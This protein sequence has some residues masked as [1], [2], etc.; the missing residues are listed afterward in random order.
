MSRGPGLVLQLQREG[1]SLELTLVPDEQRVTRALAHGAGHAIAYRARS[2]APALQLPLRVLARAL[3]EL[4]TAESTQSVAFR[5]AAAVSRAGATLSIGRPSPPS[6][7]MPRWPQSTRIGLFGE[8]DDTALFPFDTEVIALAAGLRRLLKR[9]SLRGDVI[10]RDRAWLEGRGLKVRLCP[11]VADD[12]AVLFASD[13]ERL[14]DEAVVAEERHLDGDVSA[15]RFL[16]DAL[17]YPS[18]CVEAFA[19][20]RKHDD[21]TMAAERL[22]PI[23]SAPAPPETL[24]LIGSLAIISH[25]P[26][27]PRCAATIEL[28]RAILRA[29]DDVRPGRSARWR[30]LAT[31]VH[32]IDVEGVPWSFAIGP[33]DTI[34]RADRWGL[35]GEVPRLLR[36]ERCEGAKLAI[37]E[38]VLTAPGLTAYLVADH[39]G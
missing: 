13:D 7:P 9:D 34:V 27:S 24:W 15:E 3:A 37:V 16:G 4:P 29:G 5:L 2:V 36:E 28:A 11:R 1:D 30:E 17:G 6:Q 8:G 14:L 10:D 35:E 38:G 26:C 25:V 33:D 32:A 12:G 31:R 21:L 22:E 18:C 23:S 39:R 19:L 20:V